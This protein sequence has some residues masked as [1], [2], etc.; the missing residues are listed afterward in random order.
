MES[1]HYNLTNKINQ[2]ESKT[3]APYLRAF[4]ILTMES[5]VLNGVRVT[6]LVE[7]L[8]YLNW[9]RLW[10]RICRNYYWGNLFLYISALT[11]STE[12][13]RCVN[14]VGKA[15]FK[16]KNNST[17]VLTNISIKNQNKQIQANMY[18]YIWVYVF[19]YIDIS[20][21]LTLMNSK[22]Y[23]TRRIFQYF[24]SFKKLWKKE[25]CLAPNG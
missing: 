17:T 8:G 11:E 15:C 5:G 14:P 16:K 18:A 9:H 3:S 22:H 20:N 10:D 4:F 23:A 6:K 19:K 1:K 25:L 7:L 2:T 13:E 21:G 24:I 12:W